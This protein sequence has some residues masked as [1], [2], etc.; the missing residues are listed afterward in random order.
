MAT[1][2]GTY[3]ADVP[4]I[5][6]GKQLGFKLGLESKLTSAN[7]AAVEGVFYLTSDTHRLFIG[8]KDGN[9]CPVNQG[10]IQVDSLPE[11][12][13]AI[14]GQFYYIK[15]SNVLA[16]R[17]GNTWVQ[18]N[19]DTYV[20]SVSETVTGG[21][22][23]AKVT[24]SVKHGGGKGNT[25]TS[26]G[27]T[28]K[29]GG[30]NVVTVSGS[31][32]TITD[33]DFGLS[34]TGDNDNGIDINLMT[35]AAGGTTESV[36]DKVTFKSGTGIK[37]TRNGD[38]ITIDGSALSNTASENNITGA[39]I[40]SQTDGFKLTLTKGS[41]STVT[42]EVKPTITY[43]T[44]NV[45]A[46]FANGV[47]DLDVYTQEETDSKINAALRNFD[48]LKYMG[49]VGGTGATIANLTNASN[50]ERGHVYMATG[51]AQITVNGASGTYDAGTLFIATGD[52]NETTGIIANP[53][54]TVVSNFNTDTQTNV[55]LLTNGI[56]LVNKTSDTN[57]E[58]GG[59]T[60]NSGTTDILSVTS[61]ASETGSKKI[62]NVTIAH[63][64]SSYEA[65]KADTYTQKS[66][67]LMS[68]KVLTDVGA[69]GYGHLKSSKEEW[70]IV[71][72][73]VFA[74]AS[75]TDSVTVNGSVATLSHTLTLKNSSTTSKV[76]ETVVNTQIASETLEIKESNGALAMNLIWGSFE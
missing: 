53:T 19:P 41:G 32:I 65:T 37:L 61:K 40:D 25:V 34:A 7:F 64:V 45:E 1:I 73:E 30:S 8:N 14:P 27:F 74:D 44:N 48:A 57:V 4:T 62:Q 12:A 67:D 11:G 10:V 22:N 13:N 28:V 29:G 54:W 15:G 72:G 20:D 36:K 31:E 55:E 52:E 38:E 39:A 63:G 18:I 76:T 23:N 9:V 26:A 69:D 5:T 51:S 43:G 60:V 59:I 6:A 24:T 42:A 66:T 33:A 2:V 56:K 17:S 68:M 35:T 71:P 75:V 47:A 58:I 70:V 46:K 49:T 3:T 16:T 50:V 21:T